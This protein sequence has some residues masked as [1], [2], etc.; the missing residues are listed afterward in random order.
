MAVDRAEL[1]RFIGP[2]VPDG[3]AVVVEVFHVGV[4]GEEPQQLVDDR[5]QMELLGGHKRKT[6]VQVEAH[7][8]AEHAQGSSAGAVAFAGAVVAHVAH[9]VEILPHSKNLPRLKKHFCILDPIPHGNQN[10]L[11]QKLVLKPQTREWAPRWRSYLGHGKA[12][13]CR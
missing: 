1:A 7:L 11:P 13:L 10:I 9:Q 5:A 8:A 4:A 6:V 2:L 12:S 3:D